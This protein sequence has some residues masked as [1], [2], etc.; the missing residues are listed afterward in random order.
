MVWD[1]TFDGRFADREYAVRTFE[2]H[3]A[4]VRRTVPADHLLEFE[5]GQGWE[6]LCDFLDRPVPESPF[7]RL[8][9]AKTLQ[10]RFAAIRWG[11]RAVPVAVGHP[12]RK[13]VPGRVDPPG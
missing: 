1:G 2:E 9:D 7:P 6:P 5:V 10:R 13:A 11:T 4:E 3:N 12:G 8:N